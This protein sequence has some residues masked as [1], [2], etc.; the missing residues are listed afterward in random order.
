MEVGFLGAVTHFD[1]VN[2]PELRNMFVPLEH[3]FK[4]QFSISWGF[5][6]SAYVG[7]PFKP[8]RLLSNGAMFFFLAQGWDP[9]MVFNVLPHFD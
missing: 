4:Y 9:M 5:W 8:S 6:T 3:Y 2:S 7:I 1:F